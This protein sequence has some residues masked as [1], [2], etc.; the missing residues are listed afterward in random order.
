M[1]VKDHSGYAVGWVLQIRVAQNV[2]RGPPGGAQ[3][4]VKG[5]QS[6]KMNGFYCYFT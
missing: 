4:S 3:R 1:G 2:V 6:Q 5:G